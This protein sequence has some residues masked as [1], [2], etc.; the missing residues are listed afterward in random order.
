MY[1]AAQQR[2][3]ARQVAPDSREENAP[4]RVRRAE[5]G[6][7][8]YQVTPDGRRPGDPVEATE[9]YTAPSKS[10]YQA[11]KPVR[12]DDVP[13]RRHTKV[14]SADEVVR[15][16]FL[17][18]RA[19]ANV[20][21]WFNLSTFCAA[22]GVFFGV[23]LAEVVYQSA[24]RNV[25][26]LTTESLKWSIFFSTIIGVAALLEYGT[27]NI[28][29]RRAQGDFVPEGERYFHS[30]KRCG[31]CSEVATLMGLLCII[32]VPSMSYPISVWDAVNKEEY[33]TYSSDTFGVM[34]MLLL[35][36]AFVVKC[37][38]MNDPLLAPQ[39]AFYAKCCN[40]TLSPRFILI[41]RLRESL[42]HVAGFW[43]LS[44][45]TLAYC[46]TLAE[47]PQNGGHYLTN[48][49][50]HLSIFHNSLWL[51]IVTL[52]GVGIGDVYPQTVLG[53]GLAML[54]SAVALL[55][56]ACTLNIVMQRIA[57]DDASKRVVALTGLA[58]Q[59]TQVRRQ[60]VRCIERLYLLRYDSPKMVSFTRLFCV[61][62]D[63]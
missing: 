23:V 48:A 30:L 61:C 6:E 45:I 41:V 28:K 9:Y 55:L 46:I 49:D 11:A 31:L 60:A 43:L 36:L 13:A 19:G 8:W 42:Q 59:H 27:C 21:W 4:Q 47:R 53:M 35:R 56:I 37:V 10:V 44:I 51:T 15:Q 52:T 32:P 17:A 40:V 22:S 58:R 39:H 24:D 16:R 54:S 29:L 20:R 18:G 34:L 63:F 12:G 14:E 38:V 62:K 57:L 50:E 25:P 1:A 7:G 33:V 5:Y 3:K 26:D 2:Q